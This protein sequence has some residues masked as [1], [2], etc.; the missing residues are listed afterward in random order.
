MIKP[1]PGRIVHFTPGSGDSSI[2]HPDKTQPLAAIV[3]YVWHDRMVNLTVFDQNGTP[4][5]RTSVTLLQDDDIAP[6]GPHAQWMD[7]QKGQ[8]AKAEAAMAEKPAS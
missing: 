7:Y 2:N 1:T 8:A 4:V 6:A 5:V 3:T